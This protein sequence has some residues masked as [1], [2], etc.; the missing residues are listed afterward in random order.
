MKITPAASELKPWSVKKS[1]EAVKHLENL[2][3]LPLEILKNTRGIPNVAF[4]F[5][6]PFST[7][8]PPVLTTLLWKTHNPLI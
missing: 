7:Q 3:M 5:I 4:L 6:L 1:E 8:P 2:Q